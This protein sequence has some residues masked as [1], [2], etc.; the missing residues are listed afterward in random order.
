V[1]RDAANVFVRQPP[2][3]AVMAWATSA[4]LRDVGPEIALADPTQMLI[5]LIELGG[6]DRQEAAGVLRTWMLDRP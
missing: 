2:D 1:G 3:N 6:A 4:K 5:D